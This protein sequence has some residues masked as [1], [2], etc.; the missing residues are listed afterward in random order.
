MVLRRCRKMLP[1]E[2]TRARCHAGHLCP[3]PSTPRRP[4]RPRVQLPAVPRGDQC[5]PQP[6]AQSATPAAG[7]QP[8]ICWGGSRTRARR[9][10]AA[11]PGRCSAGSSAA[12]PRSTGTIAVLHLHDGLTLEQTADAVGMSVSGVRKRLRKLR[13]ALVELE[14]GLTMKIPDLL[15]E[16][17]ALGELPADEGVARAGAARGGRRPAPEPTRGVR[18][19]DPRRLPARG[20]RP[21]DPQSARARGGRSRRR[22]GGAGGFA[23]VTVAAAAAGPGR[24]AAGQ[25]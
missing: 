3:G 19:G 2:Q 7:F 13:A 23:T 20:D 17:L 14:G 16:Q 10:I 12:S 5:V 15:V 1:D 6:H 9:S 22:D 25:P 11:K 8:A 24:L 4:R 21:A 18:C